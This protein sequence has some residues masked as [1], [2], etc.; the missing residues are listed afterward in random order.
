M[1]NLKSP[2]LQDIIM[3]NPK[4]KR[5]KAAQN[6]HNACARHV[7]C[8]VKAVFRP[9]LCS[10][11]KETFS[12][13]QSPT[14]C[15][16]RDQARESY[17][18]WLKWIVKVR[19]ARNPPLAEPKAIWP[20]PEVRDS[21]SAHWCNR[22]RALD[23]SKEQTDNEGESSQANELLEIPES[24]CTAIINDAEQN[25]KLQPINRER[26]LSNSPM[27]N[28]ENDWNRP[29]TPSF[30]F[31]QEESPN[32]KLSNPFSPLKERN[33]VSFGNINGPSN[34]VN[35]QNNPTHNYLSEDSSVTD[36]EVV[37]VPKLP[38][39]FPDDEGYLY[40]WHEKFGRIYLENQVYELSTDPKGNSEEMQE[41]RTSE[42]HTPDSNTNPSLDSS[43]NPFPIPPKP[44][45][46]NNLNDIDAGN[47]DDPPQFNFS[48]ED[49]GLIPEPNQSQ[50]ALIT[51]PVICVQG[52]S[53]NQSYSVEEVSDPGKFW[54]IPPFGA[55]FNP[56][57][58]SMSF[59]GHIFSTEEIAWGIYNRK[60][61]FKPLSWNSDKMSHLIH[62]SKQA[63]DIPRE[64]QKLSSFDLVA[65]VIRNTQVAT[66]LGWAI[67]PDNK[68]ILCPISKETESLV[69][70]NGETADKSQI[71]E[72]KINLKGAEDERSKKFFETMS[73][74][75]IDLKNLHM[76]GPLEHKLG[77]I[78][79]G[80]A[81]KD[82]H[83]RK[84]FLDLVSAKS[85]FE[86]GFALTSHE[87]AT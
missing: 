71:K 42:D 48:N 37:D 66:H 56:T 77:Y 72:S 5:C 86:L 14:N 41:R 49:S 35:V 31:I 1:V 21:F 30:D 17:I 59:D 61:V 23:C 55:V 62:F 74:S 25:S 6:S 78:E 45:F 44:H 28:E 3:S 80:W 22:F 18:T 15:S 27:C 32:S 43:N 13:A 58:G 12:L 75:R 33:Q 52:S 84:G 51:T 69:R 60:K 19:Q 68:T 20:N 4:C 65:P 38:G 7:D 79:A 82:F 39:P 63:Y 87:A 46:Q 29:K 54:F 81:E 34:S 76:E 26:E 85:L 40:H 24:Y 47:L 73:A 16:L 9:D 11:C 53:K 8:M 57:N 83:R 36:S 70:M 64:I 50:A 10:I 67:T 2:S